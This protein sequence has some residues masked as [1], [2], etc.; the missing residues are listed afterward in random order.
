MILTN[1]AMPR[2]PI[3]KQRVNV[4]LKSARRPRRVYA[5]RIDEQHANPRKLWESM[6]RPAYLSAAQVEK[7]KRASRLV[8]EDQRWQYENGHMSCAVTVPPHGIA[9]VTFEFA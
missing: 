8:K 2:H 6:G 3:R 4:R 1:H 7:L 5:E 9:A